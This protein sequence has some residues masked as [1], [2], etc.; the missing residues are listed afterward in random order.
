MNTAFGE[1]AEVK[2]F[3][4]YCKKILHQQNGKVELYEC[5][6]EIIDGDAK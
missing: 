3:H 6:T 2:T 4:A 1:L 5:L